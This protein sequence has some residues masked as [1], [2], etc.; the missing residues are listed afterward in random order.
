MPARL[1][2]AQAYW[3]ACIPFAMLKPKR[4][5]PAMR[6]SLRKRLAA[7]VEYAIGLSRR[8]ERE[9]LRSGAGQLWEYALA[10]GI[11]V[12]PDRITGQPAGNSSTH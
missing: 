9:Q 7:P 10:C 5:T 2:V 4:E 8:K 3:L 12:H 1:G 6:A 11:E